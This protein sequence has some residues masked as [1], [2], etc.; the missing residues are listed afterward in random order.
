M[1]K[2]LLSTLIFAATANAHDVWV[3]APFHLDAGKKLHA[4]LGYG[5]FPVKEKIAESRL[6][7]FPPMEIIDH[8]GEKSVLKQHGENY[9]FESEQPLAKGT[10]WATATYRPTFWSKNA[11]GKWA[12]ENLQGMQ[13]AVYCE[14]SQMFGKSLV[15]VGDEEHKN[16]IRYPIGHELEIVPLDDL[17][18]AK[19]GEKFVLQIFYEGEPLAGAEVIATSDTFIAKDVQASIDHREPQAFSG[20]TDKKGKINF[21]PLID[22]LWKVKVIHKAPFNDNKICQNK[23]S[24]ATLV[25]PVGTERAEVKHEGHSH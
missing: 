10:Y 5:D 15:I 6:D 23:A 3:D 12:R 20:K 11:E 25:I 13:D 1:K 9:Q 14:Q 2:L 24:Y 8:N 21:I 19:A 17:H 18:E 22:G 4:E 16:L 7:I